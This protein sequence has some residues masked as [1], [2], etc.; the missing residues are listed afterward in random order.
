MR[1]PM[2]RFPRFSLLVLL[3][4]LAG[5]G[6]TCMPPPCAAGA[7][8]CACLEG[9]TCH[10]GLACGSDQKCAPAVAAGV[11]IADAAARGCEFVLT[12]APGTEVVSVTFKNSA[13]G[14]WV[15]EAP[16]V[17]VTVLAGGDAALGDAVQLGLTGTASSLTLSKA[18]CVDLQGQRLATTLSIR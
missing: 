15:R 18:S 11:Q 16:R 13:K 7:Q 9:G 5:A 6:C 12:E 8:A 3:G 1:A 2:S 10:D 14:T 17:A 4:S